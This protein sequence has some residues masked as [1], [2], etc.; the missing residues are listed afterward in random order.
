MKAN[1][2]I[3]KNSCRN[4][5]NVIDRC[6]F[7]GLKLMASSRKGR[8]AVRSRKRVRAWSKPGRG[9]QNSEAHPGDGFRKTQYGNPRIRRYGIEVV[10]NAGNQSGTAVNRL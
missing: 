8:V 2:T 10:C 3:L 1:V 5:K 6:F 9:I 7:F 4:M